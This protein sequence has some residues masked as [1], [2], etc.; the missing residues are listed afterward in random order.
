[1][2]PDIKR[3]KVTYC[4]NCCQMLMVSYLMVDCPC[5]ILMMVSQNEIA[6]VFAH[7]FDILS[8]EERY[9]ITILECQISSFHQ[10]EGGV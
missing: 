10:R 9:S 7:I 2:S 4:I 5:D 3:E 6:G 1:M 8:A